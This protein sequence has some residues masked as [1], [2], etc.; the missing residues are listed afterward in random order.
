MGDSE[1]MGGG[2][3]GE[4]IEQDGESLGFRKW[5]NRRE[6]GG[7]GL[8]GQVLHRKGGEIVFEGKEF[9]DAADVGVGDMTSE[10]E[11]S[12]EAAAAIGGEVKVFAENFEGNGRLPGLDGEIDF[13][14]AA[15][16]E[17]VLNGEAPAHELARGEKLG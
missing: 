16:A 4:E 12:K 11:F 9:E 10:G 14:H 15:A 1:S 13:A 6:V 5:A 3:T 8:A 7:Q 2:E 17:K